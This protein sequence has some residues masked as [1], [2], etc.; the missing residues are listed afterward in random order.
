MPRFAPHVCTPRLVGTRPQLPRATG[1]P[2][3]AATS[4]DEKSPPT[5]SH[6]SVARDVAPAR[7]DNLLRPCADGLHRLAHGG[8][9]T[10]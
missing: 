10:M 4:R 8:P 7:A 5:E 2:L 3:A 6:G 1:M 9:G